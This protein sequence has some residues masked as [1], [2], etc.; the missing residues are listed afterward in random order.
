MKQNGLWHDIIDTG[1]NGLERFGVLKDKG[2]VLCSS[3]KKNIVG[4][5]YQCTRQS[6]KLPLY[7]N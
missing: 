3:K 7:F 6:E 4:K 5:P 1:D 2:T